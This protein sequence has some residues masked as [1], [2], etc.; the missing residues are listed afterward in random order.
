MRGGKRVECE[1]CHDRFPCDQILCG[2]LDC[3][4]E[5]AEPGSIIKKELGFNAPE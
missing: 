1:T 4:A 3:Q 2:H 5:R